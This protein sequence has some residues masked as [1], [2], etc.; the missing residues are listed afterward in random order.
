MSDVALDP[1]VLTDP[2]AHASG[3]VY[4]VW[5][6]MRRHAPVHWHSSG[7]YPGFWSVTRYEDVR[8]VYKDPASFSSTRGVMLRP[9]AL[10]TDPAGGV[11]LALSDP[12]RHGAMRSLVADL[13]TGRSARELER[14]VR[15]TART[16]VRT[17]VQSGGCDFVHDVAA[18]LTMSVLGRLLGVP[19]QDCEDLL[20]WM[21][22]SFEAGRPLATHPEFMGFLAELMDECAQDPGDDMVSRLVTGTLDGRRLSPAEVLLNCENII[23]AAENSGLSLAGGVLA[24]A[25][26]PDQWALLVRNREHLPNAVNEI[27]RWTSSATHSMRTA[28]TEVTL[29][30]RT[31]AAGERVVLWLPSA[32]RDE[33]AF[34][35]PDE[36]RVTRRPNRHL[37]F[38]AG[39]H[40]CIGGALARVQSTALLSELLDTG[41]WFEP[42]GPAEP[43]RSVVVGGPAH[44]PVRVTAFPSDGDAH[45][46]RPTRTS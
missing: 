9:T 14:Q 25:R 24:F 31:V 38:G 7:T 26:R 36:F 34:T 3:E 22:Q 43:V 33:E 10:G 42:I 8:Q 6:W 39:P 29:G 23:G 13:F 16:L 21:S 28:T 20:G 45:G 46:V 18:R 11:T 4:E 2:R 44:L 19:K 35:D 40:A 32:N 41:R 12:P 15:A 30:G 1:A 17:A 37:S 5:R 27:L